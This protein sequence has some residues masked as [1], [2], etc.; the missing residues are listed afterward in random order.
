MAREDAIKE[1]NLPS[2]YFDWLDEEHGAIGVRPTGVSPNNNVP[3]THETVMEFGKYTAED[4]ARDAAQEMLAA[5]QE[6]LPEIR[7]LNEAAGHTV[8]NPTATGMVKE[9]MAKALSQETE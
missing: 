9:A 3:V 7:R 8:F 1:F 6:V 5:L 4:C 2:G